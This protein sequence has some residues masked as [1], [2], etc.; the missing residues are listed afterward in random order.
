M[1][2]TKKKSTMV[3]RHTPRTDPVDH[4]EVLHEV[5]LQRRPGQHQPPPGADAVQRLP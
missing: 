5:V 3:W 1:G 4:G 2:Q